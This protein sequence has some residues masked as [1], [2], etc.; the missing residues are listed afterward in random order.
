M[1]L[2]PLYIRVPQTSTDVVDDFHLS[3]RVPYLWFQAR[4][5]DM[6]MNGL[7]C[8]PRC[9][10]SKWLAKSCFWKLTKLFHTH[11][12]YGNIWH[13]CKI[14]YNEKLSTTDTLKLAVFHTLQRLRVKLDAR[15]FNLITNDKATIII[16]CRVVLY[17]DYFWSDC[18]SISSR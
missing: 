17:Y 15:K 1:V 3:K 14:Y 6:I 10:S 5:Y 13:E 7:K 8:T 18:V 4:F 9:R 16:C 12:I 11:K 2:N